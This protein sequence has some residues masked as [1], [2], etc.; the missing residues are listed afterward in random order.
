MAR[1][2]SHRTVEFGLNTKSS[3]DFGALKA[4]MVLATTTAADVAGGAVYLLIPAG[5]ILGV[6]LLGFWVF[7]REAPR[8]AEEL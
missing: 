1:Y 4:R 6:F 8:I 2:S 3:T 7:N 5:I